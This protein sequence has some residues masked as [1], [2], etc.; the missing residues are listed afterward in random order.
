M[1]Q[2]VDRPTTVDQLRKWLTQAQ[3]NRAAR[4]LI[5]Y[6]AN[7]D[8]DYPISIYEAYRAKEIAR[9]VFE[10]GPL[11]IMECYNT[12]GDIESQLAEYRAF[13]W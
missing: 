8:Y 10:T 7:L 6:D 9:D 13:H 2:T 4:V 11:V 3:R 5:I 1:H 12:L